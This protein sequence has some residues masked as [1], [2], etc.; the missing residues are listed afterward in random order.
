MQDQLKYE[1]SRVHKSVNGFW[2]LPESLSVT[3]NL[4]AKQMSKDIKV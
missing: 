3:Y 2:R 4:R 1:C